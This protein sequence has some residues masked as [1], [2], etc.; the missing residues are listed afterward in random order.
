MKIL[1]VLYVATLLIHTT[2][3]AQDPELLLDIQDGSEGSSP[4]YFTEVNGTLFFTADDGINGTELW[5]T[6]GTKNGTVMVKD[7]YAGPDGSSP[8][9]LTNINGTLYFKAADNSHGR[10]VWKSDGTETG[11]I[12]LKDIRPGASSGC[13]FSLEFFYNNGLCYFTAD[14]G[15]NGSEL[16]KTDGTELGTEMVK[17]I[18]PG[19]NRSLPHSF[20]LIN[21]VVV[22]QADEP[23]YGREWWRTD[24]TGPGTVLLKDV[25]AGTGGSDPNPLIEF[26]GSLYFEAYT[27]GGGTEVW[28]T[29]GTQG[30]TVFI[31]DINPNYDD[32]R[33]ILIEMDGNLF[34]SGSNNGEDFELW[35]SDGSSAN[36]V[37]DIWVGSAGSFPGEFTVYNDLLYF[38]ADDGVLGEE[39]Y[40]SDGTEKNTD[41]VEDQISGP[42]GIGPDDLFVL[43]NLLFFTNNF[44]HP[45]YGYYELWATN[46]L[47]NGSFLVKDFYP[48]TGG[49]YASYF[50]IMG[51]TVYFKA[52]DG[53]RG[54]ELWILPL[55]DSGFTQVKPEIFSSFDYILHQNFPNPFNPTTKIKFTIPL[56]VKREMLN[57][58]LKVYDILGNE[59]ATLV[60][61]EKPAGS[62]EVEFH[63]TSH[64]GEV[65][66]LP[67]GVYYY[68]LKAG[69]YINTKKML[70]IK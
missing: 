63:A 59:I 15:I 7:I 40:S 62:Y 24:G 31:F 46:G 4:R 27:A 43:G 65:R 56:N 45:T 10:E 30:G 29:D 52:D 42:Q 25:I 35:K 58:T 37:K 61:E 8:S 60:N 2:I 33:S 69:S 3:F 57:V 32:L 53:V 23:S 13:Q 1:S 21:G 68:Q 49:G 55:P 18:Y 17:D 47:P 22:F 64:S 41:I 51:D 6:D 5:K 19:S 44:D 70:L 9:I 26:D 14:D 34:F 36:L 39:L 12:L 16:W 20:R 28:K 48:G 54:S 66:N 50:T 11:T 67:S 38:G